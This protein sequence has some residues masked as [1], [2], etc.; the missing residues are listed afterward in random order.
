MN[1][2]F[3]Q[4]ENTGEDQ[5]DLNDD[6]QRQLVPCIGAE[7]ETPHR[8]ELIDSAADKLRLINELSTEE[9]KNLCP[10]G[11]EAVL[12]QV[13][14]EIQMV[15]DHPAPPFMTLKLDNRASRGYYGDGYT[16]DKITGDLAGSD[17]GIKLNSQGLEASDGYISDDPRVALE[18]YL[19]EFR[20][21]FQHEQALRVE[22]L[23]FRNL[24]ADINEAESWREN[25]ENYNHPNSNFESYYDQTV[26]MDARS[27]AE[28]ILTKL[29][30]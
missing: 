10:S 26:E 28:Q 15:Y 9:W 7:A 4:I 6:L 5:I 27:F 8:S 3:E 20:H 16:S 1:N 25:F 24:V 29:Y 18:T 12:R 19:H 23:Q 17:Y 14:R 2:K 30:K 13:G 22:Q 21:S 11:R